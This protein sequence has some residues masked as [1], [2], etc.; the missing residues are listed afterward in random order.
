M[1]GPVSDVDVNRI[2]VSDRPAPRLLEQAAAAQLLVV[3]SHGRGGFA[4]M[5]LGSVSGA[6]V[7]AAQI[8]VIIARM[9][10]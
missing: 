1:A 8:P 4:G 7:N 10:H 9:P 6:L 3:G 5:L 2:V